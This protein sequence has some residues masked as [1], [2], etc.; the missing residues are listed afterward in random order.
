MKKTKIMMV[1]FLLAAVALAKSPM[2]DKNKNHE[3]FKGSFYK[4]LKLTD[5]QTKQLDELRKSREKDTRADR[6]KLQKAHQKLH[7]EL[8]KDK[9]NQTDIEIYKQDIIALQAKQLDNMTQGMLDLKKVLTKE[10]QEILKKRQ[11]KGFRDFQ[12]DPKTRQKQEVKK[13]KR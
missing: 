13:G 2:P 7:D 4:E 1:V 10:Q 12:K 5:D 6:D 11:E 3:D 8:F 9:P